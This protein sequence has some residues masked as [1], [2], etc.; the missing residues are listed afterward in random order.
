MVNNQTTLIG[1]IGHPLGHSLSPRMHNYTLQKMGVNCVYLPFEVAPA[2][3]AEAVGGLRA[4]NIRGVNVTIP[5]KQAVINYLDDLTPAARACG[6][7]NLI[8]NENGRLIGYNTDGPGFMASL[9]EAGVKGNRVMLLG[10]GGAAHSLAYELTAAG[11]EDMQILDLDRD[12][13]RELAGFVRNLPGGNAMGREMTDELFIQL[14]AETDLIV[15]CTPVGMFPAVDFCPVSSL[16]Q[17]PGDAVVYDLIYNPLS[18]RFLAM[19]QARNLKVI[20]GLSMLV[21]QGALSLEILL[22]VQPPIA[23]MKEVVLDYYAEQ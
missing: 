23:Y 5:F 2:C 7:V 10:A 12:K 13:A 1:L 18:T 6:A 9:A 17:V 22:G 21:H 20:N 14:S 16:T 4:L 19:A 11:V 8:K 15:N 3:L